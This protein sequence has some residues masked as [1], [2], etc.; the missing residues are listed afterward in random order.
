ME[1]TTNL[2][3]TDIVSRAHEF[4]H[5]H[6]KK[7]EIALRIIE[8]IGAAFLLLSFVME[9]HVALA[10]ASGISVIICV[11]VTL[12]VLDLLGIIR[13]DPKDHVF[14]PQKINN[15]SLYYEEDLPVLKIRADTHYEAGYDHGYLAGKQITSVIKKMN[16][17]KTLGY[18]SITKEIAQKL[19]KA[20]SSIPKS[21][22]EELR[23]LIDG[24]NA[25][26]REDSWWA[27]QHTIDDAIEIHLLPDLMHLALA[28]NCLFGCTVIIGKDQKTGQTG[29][30][31]NLDWPGL[32][33]G[34][35]SM[36]LD[37]KVGD[38]KQLL[39]PTI[40]GCVGVITGINQSLFVSINVTEPKGPIHDV[41]DGVP[42]LFLNR[43]VLENATTLDDADTF[44]D[45]EDPTKRP[46]VPYH[47]FV[48]DRKGGSFYH[49][50]QGDE[51][52]TFVRPLSVDEKR[53]HF[54]LNCRHTTEE[55]PTCPNT[56][57]YGET[58]LQNIEKIWEEGQDHP[59]V[60]R[61]K[62]AMRAP[63]VNNLW[64]VH[65]ILWIHGVLV[66]SFDNAYA[67]KGQK[68]IVF[69]DQQF[70]NVAE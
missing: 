6:S 27:P 57:F 1:I 35:Y 12:I 65:S 30:G 59:L 68:C 43:L 10:A 62:Y 34:R 28:P 32:G 22:M 66:F 14:A 55:R 13:V 29:V 58:R 33:V 8:G 19:E 69:L 24:G 39:L 9:A 64:T 20:K 47:M 37:I 38:Q 4:A 49:F 42:S 44:I 18:I 5:T 23:G 41:S 25:R 31:R 45:H 16:I 70:E 11:E 2:Q 17:L 51:K 50:L 60:Q 56:M 15:S 3:Q 61:L 26:L 21:H 52:E 63:G 46:A 54:T 48:A 53:P 67:A 7:I 40:P 36:L